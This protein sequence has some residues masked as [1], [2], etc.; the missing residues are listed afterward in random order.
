MACMAPQGNVLPVFILCVSFYL[1]ALTQVTMWILGKTNIFAA[2]LKVF[3]RQPT[4]VRSVLW[5]D[6]LGFGGMVVL[7]LCFLNCLYTDKLL[8]CPILTLSLK[9]PRGSS[10]RRKT[11][12]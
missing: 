11:L 4:F 1:G 5:L 7:W 3:Q 2:P 12:P 9:W 6:L 10:V 8:D